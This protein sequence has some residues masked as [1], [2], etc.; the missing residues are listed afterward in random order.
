MLSEIRSACCMLWVTMTIVYFFFKDIANSSTLEV[1]TGSSADVGSSISK[2]SGAAGIAYWINEHY[3]RHGDEKFTKDDKL[4]KDLKVWVDEMYADG[5]TTSLST[6]EIEG[7]IK[8]L[9]KGGE[10]K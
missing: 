9:L 2:T 3:D 4:V 5:R 10:L 6:Q 8:E 1:E 7:K